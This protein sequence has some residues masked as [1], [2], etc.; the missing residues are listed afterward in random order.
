M[1]EPGQQMPS[2]DKRPSHEGDIEPKPPELLQKIKWLLLYGSR[3]KGLILIALLV[4]VSG[5]L[6]SQKIPLG[7]TRP[8]SKLSPVI[9]RLAEDFDSARKELRT[10]G[11]IDFSSA[12]RDIQELSRLDPE[13][14]HAW[15]YAGEI[16]RVK[17]TQRFTTKGCPNILA[18]EDSFS[19]D[20]Y[21]EDFY[22]YIEHEKTLAQSEKGGSMGRAICYE[23]PGGYCNQRT[24]WIHHLLANDFLVE[25]SSIA[26]SSTRKE[27]LGRA[28]A[29]GKQALNY[30][31]DNQDKPGFE[32]CT[33]TTKIIESVQTELNHL[34]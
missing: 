33:P 21:R 23:R 18:S 19:F 10:P 22:R 24:G 7:T 30:Y 15:Y 25:A 29:H 16:K 11:A 17:N 3:H 6:V 27:K 12:E 8:D 26:S 13:N 2:T 14:G 32:Q 9:A 28:L 20:P 1:N 31:Q 4:S 5:L 34:Q